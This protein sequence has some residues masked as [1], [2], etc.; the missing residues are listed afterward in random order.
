M[1]TK[2]FLSLLLAMV[3]AFSMAVPVFAAEPD[4]PDEGIMPL[5][6]VYPQE[7]VSTSSGNGVGPF[8][9][10][11][12][13]G[14]YLQVWFANRGTTNVTVVL[15][16]LTNGTSKSMTV[17]WNTSHNNDKLVYEIPNPD[18]ANTFEIRFYSV[19][20]AWVLG[21][22]AAAQYPYYPS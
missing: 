1:K 2:R 12:G 10:S 19:N 22:V 6:Q 7:P 18:V 13:A 16:D 20:S 21:D 8:T 17:T 9:T 3:M 14:K 4:D 15:K 5:A 11:P